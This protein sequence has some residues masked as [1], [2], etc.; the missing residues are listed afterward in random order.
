MEAPSMLLQD[1]PSKVSQRV[2]RS[3][4][5]TEVAI[6][7]PRRSRLRKAFARVIPGKWTGAAL[8]AA[9]TRLRQRI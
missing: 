4:S 6:A 9:V 8:A 7:A 5:W 1:L 2:L 3:V